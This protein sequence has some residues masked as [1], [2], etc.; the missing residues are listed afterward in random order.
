[1]VIVWLVI[2]TVVLSVHF[3]FPSLQQ[4]L[5]YRQRLTSSADDDENVNA[6]FFGPSRRSD[7]GL[8]WK[9]AIIITRSGPSPPNTQIYATIGNLAFE[10]ICRI[11]L[12]L[13]RAFVGT[14]SDLSSKIDKC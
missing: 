12:D 11:M 8:S 13:T 10:A 14:W 4:H 7:L 9:N 3:V 6:L 1:M 2:G 5:R